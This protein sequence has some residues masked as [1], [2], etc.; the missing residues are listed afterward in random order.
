MNRILFPGSFDPFTR[1]HAA[2]VRRALK[3]A[4]E[5]VIG[6]GV[7]VDKPGFYA[8]EERRARIEEVF[9]DEPRVSVGIYSGLTTDFAAAVGASVILR[10]I[11]SVKDFEAERDMADVNRRLTGIET[12]ILISEPQYAAVSSSIVRE[13]LRYGADVSRF[14]P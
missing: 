2:L 12:I 4:G 14:L 6:I 9:R 3:L 7:N 1:G 13:L 11:R 8:A 5:V 10:G